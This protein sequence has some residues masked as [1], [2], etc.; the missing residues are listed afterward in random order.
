MADYKKLAGVVGNSFSIG[1]ST[2]KSTF[3]VNGT[4]IQVD[5]QIDMN[6]HKIV[7]VV[8]PTGDQDAMTKKYSDD[9]YINIDQ[10]GASNGV[11]TLV[12]GKVPVTQLP[13]SVMEYKGAWDADTNLPV[14]AD[15]GAATAAYVA[16]QDLTYTADD[17]GL[18]GN[19]ITVAYT[20]GATAGAEVVTVVGSAISVQIEDGVSTATEVKAAVDGK[21][22][23]AAL[24]DVTITGTAGDPQDIVSATNLVYGQDAANAG[25]VYRVS[26]GGT[27][28]L[29][30]GNITFYVGDFAI[31]SG[32]I[33]E[34]S[35]MASGVISVFGRVGVV[36]A[37]NGDYTASN[38]TNVPAGGIEAVTV[39]AAI[40]EL[41]TEKM[42]LIVTPTNNNVV[43]TDAA[44]QA[45]DSGT[46][47][48]ALT[49]KMELITSPTNGHLA[50][51]DA[52]GQATDSGKAITTDVDAGSTTN[53]VP[54]ALAVYTAINNAVAPGTVQTIAIPLTT[55]TA[56]STFALSDGSIITKIATNVT[57]QYTAGGTLAVTC[58]AVNLQ[59]TTENDMQNVDQYSNDEIIPIATGAVITCTIGGAPAAGVSVVYVSFV[60]SAIA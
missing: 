57:T 15:G 56:A 26:V 42:D 40:D 60:T 50:A 31:Y 59:L 2:N 17:T 13:N 51:T 22:E 21:A 5:K 23:A 41:D 53:E 45:K 48:S 12:S 32:S 54:T 29:G 58:G 20:A 7:G 55:T 4:T 25:D 19:S 16:I 3:T 28:D 37:T 43:T 38:I 46:A 39:Q 27:Q 33:W 30:S 35:P 11:A 10:K 18:A 47:L 34:R 1:L 8:D 6:T 49:G 44:G 24:V 14:L 52:A 36:T 9:N